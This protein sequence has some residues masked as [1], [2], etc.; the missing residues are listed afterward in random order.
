MCKA[1]A[2]LFCNRALVP[3]ANAPFVE[4]V[5][6]LEMRFFRTFQRKRQNHS[7][8]LGP[9]SFLLPRKPC[10]FCDGRTQTIAPLFVIGFLEETTSLLRFGMQRGRLRPKIATTCDCDFWCSQY[11]SHL[12]ASL[13]AGGGIWLGRLLAAP[14]GNR[15][16]V[17]RCSGRCL[18]CSAS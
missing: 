3:L 14:P 6:D 8:S 12:Q 18:R 7:D 16:G 11:R 4:T 15:S 10:E 1:Y 2:N 5:R 17:F 9:K 13:M